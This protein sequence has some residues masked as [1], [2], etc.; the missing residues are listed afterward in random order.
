MT[1]PT[2]KL[3]DEQAWDLVTSAGLNAESVDAVARHRAHTAHERLVE[4]VALAETMYRQVWGDVGLPVPDEDRCGR[5][6]KLTRTDV[7]G[8]RRVV[9]ALLAEARRRAAEP[10]D[11]AGSREDALHALARR[12]RDG[13]HD[14]ARFIVDNAAHST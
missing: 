14:T 4:A 7:D 10:W 9:A 3:T 12:V 5:G 2:A 13:D 6:E 8:A 1:T 11:P